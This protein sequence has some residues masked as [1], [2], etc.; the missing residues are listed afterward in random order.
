M[1]NTSIAGSEIVLQNARSRP[2]REDA[3]TKILVLSNLDNP[4]ILSRVEKC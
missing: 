4:W 3:N 2:P 1:V